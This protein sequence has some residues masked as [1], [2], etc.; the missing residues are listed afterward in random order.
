VCRQQWKLSHKYPEDIPCK[1]CIVKS[2]VCDC[3][4]EVNYIYKTNSIVLAPV[5]GQ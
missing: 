1:N 5:K 4:G 2:C 3:M